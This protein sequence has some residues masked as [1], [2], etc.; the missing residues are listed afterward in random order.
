MNLNTFSGVSNIGRTSSPAAE[1]R[2]QISMT[3]S[4]YSDFTLPIPLI[5]MNSLS[6]QEIMPDSE[7]ARL[8]GDE[9]TFCTLMPLLPLL[10]IMAISSLSLKAD[11]PNRS[12][13]S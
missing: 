11:G 13:L 3:T 7:P 5:R 1:I 2:R 6:V 4:S 9:G 10:S 12:S 8:T